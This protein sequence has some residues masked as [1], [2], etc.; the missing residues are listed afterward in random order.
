MFFTKKN[1]QTRI[2]PLV[3]GL[4]G[5]LLWAD[6]SAQANWNRTYGGMY[7]DAA[8]SVVETPDTGYMLVGLTGSF[9]N[10]ASDAYLL[11]TDSVGQL[12]WFK[13]YG[14]AGVDVGRKIIPAFGGGYLIAGYTNSATLDYNFWVLRIDASGD[15]LWTREPG[16]AD[17]DRA[18][19][20][21]GDGAGNYF[22]AGE[23]YSGNNQFTDGWLV[24]MDDAGDTLWT[25]SFSLPG[26]EYFRDV[27]KLSDTR[28]AAI[29]SKEEVSGP[30]S[31]GFVLFFDADGTSIDTVY[32]DYGFGEH[33]NCAAVS[34]AD[35]KMMLGGYYTY[36][37]TNFAKSIQINVDSTGQVIFQLLAGTADDFGMHI[38][39]YGH[40]ENDRY[41]FC[42]RSSYKTSGD[43][44][45]II[46]KSNPDGYPEWIRNY[47]TIGPDD[48]VDA[49]IKTYDGGFLGV[50][51]TR[52]YGPG[53]QALL[54]FKVAVDGTGAN[55]TFVS[56]KENTL[57]AGLAVYPNPAT[58]QVLFKADADFSL[59][60]YDAKGRAIS[61]G[62]MYLGNQ[63]TVPVAQLAPGYYFGEMRFAD[64]SI[65]VE[66]IYI[67]R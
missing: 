37:T 55:N 4:G 7:D 66:K 54:M 19:S 52:S 1:I 36:D 39:S 15:T 14:G 13:T 45:G 22:I 9:G 67:A 47:G 53:T 64:G 29:G 41:F 35:K 26:N 44:Q 18:Y 61:L 58:E 60:L 16:R 6:A 24:K 63:Y 20:A 42:G 43:H 33:L 5:L 17:W 40:Y 12:Q 59:R 10:G 28:Y 57:P 38:L 3:L 27:V 11:K 65:H 21:V 46:I 31:D 8:L 32:Y 50:G 34:P 51:F 62:A 48:G 56:V 30:E 2:A 23:T 25:K 49:V